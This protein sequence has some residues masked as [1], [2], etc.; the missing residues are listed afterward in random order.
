MAR[1]E[2]VCPHCKQRMQEGYLPDAATNVWRAPSWVEG[3]PEWSFWT[4]LKMR[5]KTPLPVTAYRCPSCGY[6]EIYA[7]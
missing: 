1:S 2:P 7:K 3:K 4:G 5:G 6:V